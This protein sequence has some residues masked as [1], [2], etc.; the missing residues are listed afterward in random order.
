MT[1]IN[2]SRQ[3]KSAVAAVLA[4]ALTC[5]SACGSDSGSGDAKAGKGDTVTIGSIYPFSGPAAIYGQ[6][7]DQAWELAFDDVGKTINGHP[8]KR[9]KLDDKCTP[10]EAV[11][12]VRTAITS[13]YQALDGPGC[14][15]SALAGAPVAAKSEIPI[16][17][18]SSASSLIGDA[19]KSLWQVL[20]TDASVAEYIAGFMKE[21]GAR[22]VGVISDSNGFGQNQKDAIST[23][24]ENQDIP[25]EESVTYS[26][27]ATDFSGQISRMK[28][29][30][31]DTIYLAGYDIEIGRI[32]AQ[33]KELGLDAKFFAPDTGATADFY[34]QAGPAANGSF[35]A[36]SFIPNAPGYSEFTARWK[37]KFGTE[38]TSIGVA[39]YV[40]ARVLLDAI[41]RAGDDVSRQSLNKALA[42]TNLDLGGLGTFAFAD[43]GALKCQ[44]VLVGGWTDGTSG[45]IQK[46][47]C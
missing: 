25:V 12:A 19:N 47:D 7:A 31:V 8:I 22:S 17:T 27:G 5:L 46:A 38:P 21:K 45:L 39:V 33:S 29:A 15:G 34:K 35:Y 42:E 44:E 6:F 28:S 10:S 20:P 11:S 24:L 4:I 3:R 43:G 1:P 14:S 26:T 36:T 37:E 41:S 9:V 40:T 13:N 23:A 16:V 30:G 2:S 32:V 18:L